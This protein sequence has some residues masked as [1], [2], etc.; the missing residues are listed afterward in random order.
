MVIHPVINIFKIQSRL[1]DQAG[2]ETLEGTP[3]ILVRQAQSASELAPKNTRVVDAEHKINQDT[4]IPALVPRTTMVCYIVSPC[5]NVKHV[6][7]IR[8]C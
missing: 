3:P 5:I 1:H 2:K 8:G 7:N 6:G 4:R